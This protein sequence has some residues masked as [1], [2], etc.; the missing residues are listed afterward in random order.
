MTQTYLRSQYQTRTRD[1]KTSIDNPNKQKTEADEINE[2][3]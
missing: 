1:V 3:V 2:A